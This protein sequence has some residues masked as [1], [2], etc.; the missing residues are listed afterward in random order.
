MSGPHLSRKNLQWSAQ[1]AVQREILC[2]CIHFSLSSMHQSLDIA[3][4]EDLQFK[5]VPEIGPAPD[6]IYDDLPT[7]MYY[8][9]DSFGPAGGLREI[10]DD[11]LDDFDNDD[12][13]ADQSEEMDPSVI[14]RVGGET[15]KLLDPAGL[16][17]VEDYF[18]TI[19][20]D[21]VNRSTG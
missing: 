14:S 20:P 15:I 11:D 1:L 18:L 7:N 17:M 8:L 21:D 6:M 4:V 9:D 13:A 12:V 19:P 3:S 10:T 16:E 2:V 5:K